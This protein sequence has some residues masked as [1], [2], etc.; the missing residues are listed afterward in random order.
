MTADAS[1]QADPVMS[2]DAGVQTDSVTVT[3]VD[4]IVQ[5]SPVTVSSDAI[6]QTNPVTFLPCSSDKSSPAASM[7][8]SSKP[9]RSF[10]R[11]TRSESYRRQK[12]SSYVDCTWEVCNGQSSNSIPT[13]RISRRYQYSTSSHRWTKITSRKRS[14]RRSESNIDDS[15]VNRR[16]VER[17]TENWQLACSQSPAVCSSFTPQARLPLCPH[18]PNHLCPSCASAVLFPTFSIPIPLWSIGHY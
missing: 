9:G 3:S 4:A 8:R 15:R 14:V 13:M 16:R 10:H 12:T 7:L 6:V 11:S 18:L 1:I 17:S 2:E 5:T